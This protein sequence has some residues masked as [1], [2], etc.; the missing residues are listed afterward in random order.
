MNQNLSFSVLFLAELGKCPIP[1]KGQ[2]G[3]CDY[4]GD[5]CLQDSDCSGD[6]RCCFNG[7]QNDCVS[8]GRKNGSHYLSSIKHFLILKLGLSCSGNKLESRKVLLSNFTFSDHSLGYHPQTHK[9]EAPY[10]VYHL[11]DKYI[12]SCFPYSFL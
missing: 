6:K 9:L 12:M 2:E 3:I 10:K 11:V 5:M 7:C 4:R 1:W 8:P